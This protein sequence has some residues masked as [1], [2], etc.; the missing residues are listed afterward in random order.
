M[1]IFYA[2]LFCPP[3][4]SCSFPQLCTRHPSA[5]RRRCETSTN[6]I[7][8]EWM[9]LLS[10]QKYVCFWERL[11]EQ[12]PE[13]RASP[14]SQI[15]WLNLVHFSKSV[16]SSGNLGIILIY[17]QSFVFLAT[18]GW[19]STTSCTPYTSLTYNEPYKVD[20]ADMLANSCPFIHPADAAQH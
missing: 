7:G 20:M 19:N 1:I 11:L 3:T 5:C 2:F 4:I 10:S 15:I 14:Q 12:I 9:T 8:T 16:L 17:G 18:W 6:Q 13:Q